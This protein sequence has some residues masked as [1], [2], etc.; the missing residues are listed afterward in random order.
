MA[1][2]PVSCPFPLEHAPGPMQI[3]IRALALIMLTRMLSVKMNYEDSRG[4]RR[5]SIHG[6]A[7][8][9]PELAPEKTE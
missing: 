9:F 8:A 5:Y 6:K 1:R 3:E 7:L 2:P 4:V